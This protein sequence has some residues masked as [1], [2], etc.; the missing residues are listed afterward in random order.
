MI[1]LM[2]LLFYYSPLFSL[3]SVVLQ[4][5]YKYVDGQFL[6]LFNFLIPVKW[7]VWDLIFNN[8]GLK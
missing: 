2:D 7:E 5:F 3:T 4:V 8:L 6:S 1:K